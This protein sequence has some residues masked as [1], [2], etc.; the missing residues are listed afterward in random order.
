MFATF[1]KEKRIKADLTLR[2]FCRQLGEDA[3]N[4]SKV[5]RGILSP[6]RDEAKLKN[7]SLILNIE[8]N[9][10]DWNSLHDYA[11]VDSGSIPNYI[12]SDKDV[13]KVLPLFF[14]TVGSVKP[15]SEELLELIQNIKK[16]K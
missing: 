5:E 9:T 7:I 15:S 11:S 6:P 16:G 1:V 14:R 3:S 12:K 2:E 8:E 10:D 4:W 13:I